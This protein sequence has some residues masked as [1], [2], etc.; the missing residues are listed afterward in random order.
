MAPAGRCAPRALAPL[1]RRQPLTPAKVRFAWTATVGAA[2]ARA[3]RVGLRAD[4][5]LAVTAE[6]E[7]WRRETARAGPLIRTRLAELL[8][9]DVVRKITVTEG[10]R[11]A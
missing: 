5:T 6:S 7:H 10:P 11:H 4:G 2:A 8:G 1:L 9:P 3:T